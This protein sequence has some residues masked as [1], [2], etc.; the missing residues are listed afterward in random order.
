M[1]KIKLL[2]TTLVL[3]TSVNSQI[4][5][6]N[7]YNLNSNSGYLTLNNFAVSGYKYLS[8]DPSLQQIKLYNLNHSL[9]KTINIPSIPNFTIQTISSIYVTENLF[10]TDSQVE[11]AAQ[12][13]NTTVT[14][15]QWYLKIYDENGNTV[16][17]IPNR[18][19][20]QVVPASSNTFKLI[21]SDGNFIR[22]VYSLPGTSSNVGLPNGGVTGQVGV[23]YPNPTSQI[24]T[25]PYD[26]NGSSS[27]A[28]MNIYNLNGQIIESFN[29]DNSFNSVL[30][31]VS[32]YTS[33]TYR[34]SITVNGIE[35][36]SSSFIKQ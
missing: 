36:V 34:Y 10:N 12:Y 18:L 30:L 5:L 19:I 26:L 27:T 23:S 9:W 16:A 8:Y 14:P 7:S 6:E 17:D 31:D 20:S 22:E 11:Y 33:G 24:I 3:A 2:F 29:V 1:N 28:V 25:L 21:V 32:N 4:S 13:I 35:S 15:I